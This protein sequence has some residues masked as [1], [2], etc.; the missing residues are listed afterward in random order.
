[1]ENLNGRVVIVSNAHTDEGA[2]LARVMC[3]AGA[4]AVLTGEGFYDLGALA[5]DLHDETGA[6]IAVFAGDLSRDDERRELTAMVSE[7]FANSSRAADA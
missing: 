5:R 7:L 3:A 4:A 2:E 1:M 6:P